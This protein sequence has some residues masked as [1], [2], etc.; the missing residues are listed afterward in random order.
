MLLE[1]YFILGG[2]YFCSQL[3]TKRNTIDKINLTIK[4]LGL[5]TK[6]PTNGVLTF[7]KLI[8]KVKKDYGWDLYYTIPYGR[9]LSDFKNNA[10]RFNQ[11]I[12]GEVWFSIKDGLLKMEVIEKQLPRKIN[13]KMP[14]I[15]SNYILPVFIGYSRKGAEIYDLTDFPHML[16]GGHTNYGKSNFIRQ[17]ITTLKYYRPNTN[18]TIIDLKRIEFNYL[19]K[20]VNYAYSIEDAITYIEFFKQEAN[21]RAEI[22]D[23]HGVEKIS[24]YKGDDMPYEV[25]II[26]E[27]AHLSPELSKG[28]AKKIREYGLNMLIELIFIARALGIH[29]IIC[30][31][32]PDHKTVP[33]QLKG[34][35]G[36]TIAFRCSTDANSLILLDNTRAAQIPTI[37]GRSIFQTDIEK[38]IQVPWLD[39]SDSLKYIEEA[40]DNNA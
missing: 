22:L 37:P 4:N 8:N 39:R 5:G 1:T 24:E 2:A 26:D 35:L 17:M 31:Q 38:E 6:T 20:Y 28:N 34:E 32:R 13:F 30:T 36:A 27:F 23:K 40:C 25:L 12:N 9:C 14:K 11:A 7:P 10:E 15:D 3:S 16:V 21:R 19:K 29:I 33:G 18:I